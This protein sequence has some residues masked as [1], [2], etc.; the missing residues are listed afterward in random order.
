MILRGAFALLEEKLNLV[1]DELAYFA[2]EDEFGGRNSGFN[3]WGIDADEGKL[4]YALVRAL[5]PET[6]LEIGT[7]EGASATHLLAAV[8]ANGHGAVISY[9]TNPDAG[10]LINDALR[11]GWTF[12]NEDAVNAEL[13][14]AEFV[15]EDGDHSLTG[16][17]LTHNLIKDTNPRIVIAHDYA[18]TP[19]FGDFHVRE[20]FDSVYPDGFSIVLDGCERG[21]GVWVNPEWQAPVVEAPKPAPVKKPAPR[22]PAAKKP[23]ARTTSPNAVPAGKGTRRK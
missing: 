11:K 8:H 22:K 17:L 5:Q 14:S 21:L 15:F 16:S 9:D 12:R 13:P 10:G 20:A 4:L 18:M 2:D 7:N 19:A 1:P 3:A 6:V 23:A